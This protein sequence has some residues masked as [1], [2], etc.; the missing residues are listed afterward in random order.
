MSIFEK[1]NNYCLFILVFSVTFENWDPFQLGGSISVTYMAS[2]I[3]II[4]WLPR[5]KKSFRI[6]SVR[7]YLIPL[8]LFTIIGVI[9]TALNSSYAESIEGAYNERVITLII[10]MTLMV[11]HFYEDSTLVDKALNAYVVSISLLYFLFL[12]GIGSDFKGGRLLLFGENPNS[13]GVKVVIAFLICVSRLITEKFDWKKLLLYSVAIISCLNLIILS[14]SR[15]ALVSVFISLALLV[16]FMRI[17]IL[18]KMIFFLIGI[19]FSVLFMTMIMKS[20]P[21]FKERI[22]RTIESGDTGRSDLWQS[23]LLIIEDNLFFGV[24]LAGALPEMLRYTG[25]LIDPHNVFL[26]VLMTTGVFGLLFYLIFILRLSKNL[27]QKFRQNGEV[28]YMV[29]LAVVVFNM[30]KTGGAISKIFFWFFFAVLIGS[31]FKN[32]GSRHSDTT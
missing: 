1:L 30:G 27:Y 14:G 4:S 17:N 13:I 24:G 21:V 31:T 10:L 7:Q 19:S 9:S 5:L 12:I 25:R 6:I 29:M 15:G 18:K 28:V 11:S 23:S 8:I 26:Y 2:V 32:L 3:Y 20:N 16:L 22:L